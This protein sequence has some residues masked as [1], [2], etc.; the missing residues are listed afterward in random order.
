MDVYL[1][2][3]V[4]EDLKRLIALDPSQ[5]DQK[6]SWFKLAAEIKSRLARFIDI[7]RSRFYYASVFVNDG[8]FMSRDAGYYQTEREKIQ[9][10]IESHQQ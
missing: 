2:E 10:L 9:R 6:D 4:G 5:Q 7:D 8:D 1:P 3:Q